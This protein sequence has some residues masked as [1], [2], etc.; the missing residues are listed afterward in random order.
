MG[1][2]A[3]IVGATLYL[4]APYRFVDIYVRGAIGE[5]VAF[6]FLP[7]VLL[8]LIT[9]FKNKKNKLRY[10][11]LNFVF[12]SASF[13]FLILSHNAVS[14]LFIPFVIFYV[15]YLFF[16]NKSK[17][18]LLLSITSL[19]FGFLYSF[20][21]WFPA[22]VEGK[23]TLRDIV[24]NNAYLERYVQV[25]NL[26]YGAWNY[27]GTGEFTTQLGIINI[28]II[29]AGVAFLFK[30]YKSKD[31]LKYLLIGTVVF[32][33][34][35]VFLMLPYSNFIWEKL[36]ILQKLQFPWR[37]L[38]ITT[39]CTSVIGAI[40]IDK[41]NLKSKNI[42][43]AI[44]IILSIIPT[45]NY[46]KADEYKLYSDSYFEKPYASTT[47]TGESSPIWSVRSMDEFPKYK[48][49]ILSGN[50]E[51]VD[52]SRRSNYHEY[53]IDAKEKTRFRENTLYFPGWKI[54]DNYKLVDNVEFQDP[55]NRGVMTF[56]LDKG[57]HD[58]ILK[59]ENTKVRMVSNIVTFISII[60]VFLIP[61]IFLFFPNL[62][63]KKYRW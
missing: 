46:W 40:L 60:F 5:H 10:F 21:F 39:F 55:E 32:F 6:V 20:F 7:L 57:L 28:I 17:Q 58:L 42:L 56:Y 38:S 19:L 45:V 37:F 23:Y 51:I 34:I 27:G 9:L 33:F 41:I 14:L 11:Y 4:F 43:A 3:A 54:Y 22:F 25:K 59:F 44:I 61:L 8:S 52:Y 24:T 48:L 35:S 30:F 49:E 29:I 16:E 26:I 50:A 47:D 13:S 1:N 36:T 2:S 62:K 15:F 12:V 63:F 53:L 18:K 31:N